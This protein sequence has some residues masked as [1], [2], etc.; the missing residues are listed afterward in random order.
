VS[1][2][3][4]ILQGGVGDAEA[5]ATCPVPSV[6]E[7]SGDAGREGSEISAAAGVAERVAVGESTSA[8]LM[9]PFADVGQVSSVTE[10]CRRRR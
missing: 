4:E 3:A 6:V 5:Q 7:S 1:V 2:G 10:R 9:V 8:K